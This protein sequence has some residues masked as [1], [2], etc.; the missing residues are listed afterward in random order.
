MTVSMA[1]AGAGVFGRPAGWYCREGRMKRAWAALSLVIVAGCAVL[2]RDRF[3]APVRA[4]YEE[5]AAA[6]LA[7]A[8][9]WG[10]AL[11]EAV[12]D[13]ELR[14]PA[15]FVGFD[16]LTATF[17]YVRNDDRQMEE[18]WIFRRAVSERVGISYR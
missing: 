16:E 6:A 15:A 1:A 7:F 11:P 13:R 12:L 17:F 10:E 14:E 4:Y 3:A 18:G 9:V 5:Q 2:P 8:P